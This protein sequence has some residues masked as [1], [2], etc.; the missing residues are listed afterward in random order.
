MEV[1]HQSAKELRRV[2][3]QLMGLVQ[4][5]KSSRGIAGE[6]QLQQSANPSA[7]RKAQHIADLLSGYGPCS[8]RDR[9]V[10]DR[11]TV[12]CRAFRGAGNHPKCF[13]LDFDAFGLRNLREMRGELFS[14]NASKV[15]ALA[16]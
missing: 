4:L 5:R 15:E 10:Q 9:L 6:H 8:V 3:P 11:Q 14:R 16:T 13:V 7:V 1:L 12:A 2:D